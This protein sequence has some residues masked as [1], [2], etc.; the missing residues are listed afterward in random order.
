MYTRL[1]STF[2]YDLLSLQINIL[3]D[4][5]HYFHYFVSCLSKHTTFLTLQ[6]SK[7]ITLEW[8]HNG[9][10]IVSNHQPDDFLFNRLFRRR[11][12]KA[13]KLRVTGLCAGN[14]PGTGEF[15]AQMASN[16]ENVS[17]WWRH[18]ELKWYCFEAVLLSVSM[19]VALWQLLLLW[20]YNDMS[21]YCFAVCGRSWE[22]YRAMRFYAPAEL[23]T[24]GAVILWMMRVIS[25]RFVAYL[26][27]ISPYSELGAIWGK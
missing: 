23:T 18:H 19:N 16:A 14:S 12:K 21:R 3:H 27:V 4:I 9:R 7:Y 17:I 5:W 25:L 26:C 8:R 10:D 1:S 6:W 22:K 2:E 11:S 24:I 13:S 15:P 20:R